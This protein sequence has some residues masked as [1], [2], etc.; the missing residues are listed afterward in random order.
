MQKNELRSNLEP[1]K[2]LKEAVDYASKQITI[3]DELKPTTQH[4]VQLKNLGM[5]LTIDSDYTEGITDGQ[6]KRKGL[7]IRIETENE[8]MAI[9]RSPYSNTPSL[10]MNS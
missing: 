1:L 3:D 4:V 2:S 5:K 10:Q 8:E 9:N 6:R 7:K